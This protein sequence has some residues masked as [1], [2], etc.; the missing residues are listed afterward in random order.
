MSQSELN[1]VE[2]QNLL[3]ALTNAVITEQNNVEIVIQRHGATSLDVDGFVQLIFNMRE[4]FQPQDP[5][6]KFVRNLK[7]ELTGHDE[8]RF[9]KMRNFPMRAQIAAI[10]AAIAAGFLLVL[11]RRLGGESLQDALD[12]PVLQQ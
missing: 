9:A 2:M 3:D 10:L 5:A 1:E 4:Y 8:R 6:D 7:R 12:I 11:R